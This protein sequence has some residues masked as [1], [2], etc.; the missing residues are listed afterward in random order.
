MDHVGLFLWLPLSCGAGIWRYME[1]NCSLGQ[2]HPEPSFLRNLYTSLR[3]S[4]GILN[5]RHQ[6]ELREIKPQVS[7]LQWSMGKVISHLHE[8][9]NEWI[10][11]SFDSSPCPVHLMWTFMMLRPFP[12]EGASTVEGWVLNQLLPDSPMAF[13]AQG[14]PYL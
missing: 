1:P 13:I 9:T 5:K 6:W 4:A 10:Q 12:I 7:A 8:G 3:A 11:L 2:G 14:L